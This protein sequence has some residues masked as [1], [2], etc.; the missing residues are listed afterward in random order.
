MQMLPLILKQIISLSHLKWTQKSAQKGGA[1]VLHTKVFLRIYSPD[2]VS[3][4]K[5][6][7]CAQQKVMF[8]F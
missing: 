6:I 2:N 8:L 4:V 5:V 7:F 3:I 1:K